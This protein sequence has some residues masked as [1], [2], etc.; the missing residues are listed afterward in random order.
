MDIPST[1]LRALGLED[2]PKRSGMAL[3][4]LLHSETCPDRIQLSSTVAARFVEQ[5]PL[6]ISARTEANK[7][8]K[9]IDSLSCYQLLEDPQEKDSLLGEACP[10][11]LKTAIELA[12]A[13]GEVKA[14]KLDAQTQDA[15]EAL[16]YIE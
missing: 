11:R 15:L 10:V 13:G 12:E 14:P 2:H 16:G 8:I 1:V 9:S 3:Q 4:D 7:L 6:S 5:P